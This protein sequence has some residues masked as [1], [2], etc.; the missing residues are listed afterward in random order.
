MK[1]LSNRFEAVK[2]NTLGTQDLI[3][4]TIDEEVEKFVTISTDKAANPISINILGA[5]KL[6]G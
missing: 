2:T 5:T 1:V 4:V 6:L 3:E